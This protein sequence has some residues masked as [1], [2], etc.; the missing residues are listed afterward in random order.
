MPLPSDIAKM[1]PNQPTKSPLPMVNQ[2][3]VLKDLML[4]PCFRQLEP[5]QR[6]RL[7]T[8]DPPPISAHMRGVEVVVTLGDAAAVA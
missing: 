5:R 8:I 7:R 2:S 1:M 3:A 6:T 4:S